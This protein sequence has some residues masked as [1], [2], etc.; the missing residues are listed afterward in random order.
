MLDGAVKNPC[1]FGKCT[2]IKLPGSSERASFLLL[3]TGRG[4]VC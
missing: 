3:H 4:A 1:M 2:G